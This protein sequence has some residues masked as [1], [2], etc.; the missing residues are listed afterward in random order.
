MSS[1]INFAKALGMESLAAAVVFTILYV[2]FLVFF[3]RKSFTHPTYVHYT[4]TFFC[5]LRV[6]AFAVR[7]ILTSSASAG[8]TLGVVITDQLLSGVGYFSLLYSAYTLVLDRLLLSDHPQIDLPVLRLTQ[9]RRLFRLAL[10]IAVILGVISATQTNTDG[11]TGSLSKSLH[12][13]STVIF[14]VLTVLQA[15]Q[16]VVLAQTGVSGRS[17]YYVRGKDS[18]GV[19]YG[20]YILLVICLLLLVREIFV[21]ATVTN[22]ARQ[23]TEHFWYPLLAVPEILVV[24][25]YTT[26]GLVPRRDELPAYSPA[27]TTPSQQAEQAYQ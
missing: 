6:V 27:Y 10:L 1:R 13:A 25:L 4:L 9:N 26:P 16:T 7:A 21:T 14:L 15:I 20:N 18:I 24:L 2:P 11:S 22:S 17:Q 8:E 19:G 3:A 5:L 23:D 12:I